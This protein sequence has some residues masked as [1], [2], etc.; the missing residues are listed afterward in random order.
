M[1][2]KRADVVVVGGG[3]GG[4]TAALAARDLVAFRELW[5]AAW[6]R[7]RGRS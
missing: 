2:V 3:L 6:C 1:P 5:S 7:R 4:M